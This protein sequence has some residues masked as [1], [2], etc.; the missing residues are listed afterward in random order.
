MRTLKSAAVAAVAIAMLAVGAV[1][2]YA[3]A[4]QTGTLR[5]VVKDPSGAVIPNAS[6]MVKGTEPATQDAV[7]PEAVTDGQGVA[8]FANLAAGRYTATASFPGFETRAL[9]DLR[10]RGGDLRR[11]LTLPIEKVAHAYSFQCSSQ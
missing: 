11:D 9:A 5:I 8:T 4:R 2:A 6:V 3:Q 10:V 1:A 7:V